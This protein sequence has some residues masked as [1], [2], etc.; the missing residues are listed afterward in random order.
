MYPSCETD[1]K[2]RHI[3]QASMLQRVNH[4]VSL[5]E[6]GMSDK[7]K[8][9]RWRVFLGGDGIGQKA[10]NNSPIWHRHEKGCPVL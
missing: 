8:V 6:S 10:N 5:L 3:P 7:T 9:Q 2:M 1:G 4:S